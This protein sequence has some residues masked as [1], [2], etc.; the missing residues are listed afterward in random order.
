MSGGRYPAAPLPLADLLRA[1][2][3]EKTWAAS[4]DHGERH[5]RGVAATALKIVETAERAGRAF[6]DPDIDLLI[7][8]GIFHDSQRRNDGFDPQHG[9]RGA[10]Y[11]ERIH[12]ATRFLLDTPEGSR[13]GQLS[14]ACRGHADGLH[15]EDPIVGICWDADRLNLWR[16]GIEPDPHYF[17]HPEISGQLIGWARRVWDEPPGWEAIGERW[18]AGP[19]AGL[20]A[21]PWPQDALDL[22]DPDDLLEP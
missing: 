18:S 8:F 19:G 15:S 5:W 4:W 16:V 14:E 7:A 11:A 10:G 3:A 17:T 6:A 1:V 2:L 21:L 22:T 13:L 20:G 12:L 9:A